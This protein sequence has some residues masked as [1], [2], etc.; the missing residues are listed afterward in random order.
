MLLF[1]TVPSFSNVSYVSSNGTEHAASLPL[2]IDNAPNGEMV[3]RFTMTLSSL[4][5]TKFEVAPDD[6]LQSLIVNDQ[7]IEDTSIPF[8]DFA[9]GR[10][11][12]LHGIIHSG[13]N[14]VMALV[15][16]DGGGAMFSMTPSL[17]DAVR[18]IPPALLILLVIGYLI[19]AMHSFKRSAWE[20]I[21]A[22]IVTSG[23]FLRIFYLMVTPYWVRGHDTDGHIDY[24]RYIR[25][26]WALPPPDQG[27]EFWQPPLYYALGAVWTAVMDLVNVTGVASLFTVQAWSL[28]LSIATLLLIVWIGWR[29]FRHDTER[30]AALFIVAALAAVSPVLLFQASRIN[31]DVLAIAIAFAVIALVT[32]WWQSGK[33]WQWITA[34]VLIGLGFLTKNTTLTLIP[35]AFGCLLLRPHM[36]WKR[37]AILGA[38]SLALIVLIAGWFSVYRMVHNP[39]QSLIVGNN[40]GLSSSLSVPNTVD[41]FTT[42]NPVAVLRTP[43]ND[44]WNDVNR[45]EY[46]FEYWYRSAFFGEFSFG[47]DRTLIASWMLFFGYGL[48]ALMLVGIWRTMRSR[49]S[50]FLPLLLTLI[51]V[52]AAHV[53][54]RVKFPFSP[55]Q[56]FRYSAPLLAAAIPFIA[57][58]TIGIKHPVLRGLAIGIVVAFCLL[59]AIFFL[60]P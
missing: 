55:S 60:H 22:L 52:F 4:H 44:A 3:V 20:Q 6:C 17:F 33:F 34:C 16:N 5:A 15:R 35:I 14:D 50:P 9:K 37:K 53:V 56:D 7:P 42:F 58:G 48:I 29:V 45:R 54:F 51:F 10:T 43:Y 21:L 40:D 47:D 38:S 25:E 24:I 12:D 57:A 41:A 46:F 36:S 26:H 19:F 32:V 2:K 31:N 13:K 59:T 39:S 18:F 27:W 23:V 8:C 30:H 28:V 11:V 49:L 1:F